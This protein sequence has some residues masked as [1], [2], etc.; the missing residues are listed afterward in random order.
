M[1]CIKKTDGKEITLTC[2]DAAARVVGSILRSEFC[3]LRPPVP[4]WLDT[5]NGV[6]VSM[7]LRGRSGVSSDS[8]KLG[9]V[10]LESDFKIGL[11]GCFIYRVSHLVVNPGWIDLDFSFPS[12][13]LATYLL[14]PNSHQSR[15]RVSKWWINGN[16]IQ[17]NPVYDQMGRPVCKLQKQVNLTTA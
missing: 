3:L 8:T 4:I 9:L 15:Q 13:C 5:G 7:F 10:R 16:L 1:F 6:G 17:P 2:A 11:E 12:S 14:L